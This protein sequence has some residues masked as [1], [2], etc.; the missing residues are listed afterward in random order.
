[1]VFLDEVHKVE[2]KEPL[3]EGKYPG[4]WSAGIVEFT[5]PQGVYRGRSS[6]QSSSNDEPCMVNYRNG[7]YKVVSDRILE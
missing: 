6:V 4:T 1:M 5:T 3:K 7:Q 2:S